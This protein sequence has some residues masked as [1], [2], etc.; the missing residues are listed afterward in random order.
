[1]SISNSHF[2]VVGGED[3]ILVL[4]LNGSNSI[5]IS[6]LLCCAG[7]VATLVLVLKGSTSSSL[8]GCV[9]CGGDKATLVLVLN[10]SNSK[11]TSPMFCGGAASLLSDF[12]GSSS[13]RFDGLKFST[14]GADK[15]GCSSAPILGLDWGGELASDFVDLKGFS[16]GSLPPLSNS[17]IDSFVDPDEPG[18]SSILLWPEAFFSESVIRGCEGSSTTVFSGDTCSFAMTSAPLGREFSAL[19]SHCSTGGT[20]EETSLVG[21]VSR[22]SSPLSCSRGSSVCLTLVLNTISLS[23]SSV[24][25]SMELLVVVGSDVMQS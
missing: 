3:P 9:T 23:S 6:V 1:M 11:S 24:G 7:E 21:I 20:A 19:L 12:N 16:T 13:S 4:V 2:D 10:G 5:S 14:L 17:S 15:V 25:S 8:P 18:T 22:S